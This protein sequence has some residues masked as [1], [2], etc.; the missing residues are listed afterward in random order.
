[1]GFVRSFVR[2]DRWLDW[3]L[4]I[5]IYDGRQCPECGGLV[6][7]V[8]A[9][10]A[11]QEWHTART[12]WDSHIREAIRRLAAE[13]GLNVREPRREDAPDGIYDEDIDERLTAKAR[14]VVGGDYEEDDDER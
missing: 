12:E 2:M 11:H 6:V 10:K 14:A 1:M 9:R 4:V 13:L 8:K 3:K 7:G 5:P